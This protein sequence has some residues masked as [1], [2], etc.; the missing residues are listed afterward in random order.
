MSIVEKLAPAS[1][2]VAMTAA[3]MFAVP[4]PANASPLSGIAS[5]TIKT[6]A[7]G[8]PVHQVQHGGG[9]GGRGSFGGRGSGGGGRAAMSGGGRSGHYWRGGGGGGGRSGWHGGGYRGGS[10]GS[11]RG[12]YRGNYARAYRGN[13]G[14]AYRG[15]TWGGNR[16]YWGGNRG[17][18]WRG[19]HGGR[20]Y[21]NAYW[22][23]GYGNGYY[24][25]RYG[26]YP[27]IWGFAAGAAVG[28]ALT[29]PYYED[30]GYYD[31]SST[32]PGYGYP[33]GWEAWYAH[34]SAKY[35]SFD[36]ATGTYLGYD[37]NRHF[38]R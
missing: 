18:Y 10:W 8:S 33:G 5:T 30:Y 14:R 37:G 2:A 19:G 23:R 9:G 11:H 34:C 35:R 20:G 1:M 28:S 15:A 32:A 29:W 12:G 3:L 4:L 24:G 38:C 7:S 21:H 13:Y 36:P 17:N 22:R 26:Y 27:G 25:R 16:G 6:I 31:Y